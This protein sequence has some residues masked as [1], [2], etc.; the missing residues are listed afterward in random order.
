MAAFPV[1]RQWYQTE[2]T[3]TAS[4]KLCPSHV[5]GEVTAD[6]RENYCAVYD[7][8]RRVCGVEEG[9]VWDGRRGGGVLGEGGGVD[10]K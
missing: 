2:A 10:V 6:F 1:H 5:R 3:V 7:G 4:F 8:G 9:G